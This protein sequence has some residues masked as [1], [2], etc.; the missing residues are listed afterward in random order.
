M[1][2]HVSQLFFF[3]FKE[4]VSCRVLE[5]REATHCFSVKRWNMMPSSPLHLPAWALFLSGKTVLEVELAD[6]RMEEPVICAYVWQLMVVLR[7]STAGNRRDESVSVKRASS[8]GCSCVS[9]S[10][11]LFWGHHFD[12]RYNIFHAKTPNI[13]L[14]KYNHNLSL[15]DHADFNDWIEGIWVTV[16]ESS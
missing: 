3:S 14:F 10:T 12:N 15:I 7:P 8:T 6:G 2:M 1:F 13:L 16:K 4:V 9:L 5:S 11:S